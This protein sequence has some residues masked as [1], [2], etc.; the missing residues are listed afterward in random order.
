MLSDFIRVEVVRHT[1]MS[2]HH[3]KS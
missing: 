3:H 1:G 2:H